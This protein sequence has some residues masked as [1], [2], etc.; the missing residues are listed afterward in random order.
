MYARCFLF[1]VRKVKLQDGMD[2]LPLLA[3][4]YQLKNIRGLR[5]SM[6]EIVK[7]FPDAIIFEEEG[8]FISLYQPTHRHSPGS[9]KDP[10]VFKNL[11]QGIENSLKQKY[12]MRDIN[13][14]MKPF[15][16]KKR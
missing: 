13:S 1:K 10:I 11:I 16:E 5:F 9:K 7:I 6:Y 2:G 14:I 15:Y 8:P 4:A 3:V 12:K